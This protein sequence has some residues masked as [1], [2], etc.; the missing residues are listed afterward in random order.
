M[1]GEELRTIR[2]RLGLSQ[3]EFAPRVGLTANAVARIERGE[4]GVSPML[5]ILVGFLAPKPRP[6]GR[7]R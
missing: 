4:R 6:R 5:A 7:R 2:H 1:T 3:R